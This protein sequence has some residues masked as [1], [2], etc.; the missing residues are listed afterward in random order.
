MFKLDCI[1]LN[2]DLPNLWSICTPSSSSRDGGV[3][4]AGGL[5]QDWH[6]HLWDKTQSNKPTNLQFSLSNG[7][8]AATRPFLLLWYRV[9]ELYF[10]TQHPS[11]KLELLRSQF[12]HRAEPVTRAGWQKVTEAGEM[13]KWNSCCH[14]LTEQMIRLESL[15]KREW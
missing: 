1:I 2:Y 8:Q 9:L 7:T 12:N 11:W 3:W 5:N 4:K 13:G 10:S 15:W 6:K 14:H